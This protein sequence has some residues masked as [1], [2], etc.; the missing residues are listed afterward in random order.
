MPPTRLSYLFVA[1]IVLW[2]LMTSTLH[3][4]AART[5]AECLDL[6]FDKDVLRC[7]SCEKLLMVTQSTELQQEC[8]G[9]C[10][11]SDDDAAAANAKYTAA[12]I[13]GRNVFQMLEASSRSPLSMFYRT[14]KEQPYFEHLS[15][16]DKYSIL[17][18]QIILV[19]DEAKDAVTLRI[20][21]WSPETL[22][23]FLSK[24]IHVD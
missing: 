19:D 12:R 23:K 15:F 11:A 4:H 22:H 6:G 14:Y 3:A 21:G 1:V 8:L 9:C 13:E 16:N 10:V 20:S 18:P 5:Q 17:Y 24:K 2:A 7:T